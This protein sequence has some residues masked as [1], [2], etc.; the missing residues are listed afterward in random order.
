[1]FGYP[2]IA[3]LDAAGH[4]IPTI[5][6][7]AFPGAVGIPKKMITLTKGQR[8]YFGVYYANQTGFGMVVCPTSA[9]LRLTPPQ[10]SGSIVLSGNGARIAPYGGTIHTPHCGTVQVT[11]VTTKRFQ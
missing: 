1:M 6:N 9:K 4:P 2:Q 5:D 10:R 3:M 7:N 11:P 8:A